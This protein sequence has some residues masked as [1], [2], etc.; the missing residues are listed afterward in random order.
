MCVHPKAAA[1]EEDLA[2]AKCGQPW[3]NYIVNIISLRVSLGVN[4]VGG[5]LTASLEAL[6]AVPHHRRATQVIDNQR[7]AR[8]SK[9]AN[10]D[11][12]ILHSNCAVKC[13]NHSLYAF[14]IYSIMVAST[15]GTL[16]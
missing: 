7:A 10:Q 6:R 14:A 4:S 1:H 2:A 15:K 5:A 12:K 9:N 13:R 3:R 11:T 8:N 16:S